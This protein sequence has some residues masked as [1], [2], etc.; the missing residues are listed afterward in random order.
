[1]HILFRQ[2]VVPLFLMG[3]DFQVGFLFAVCLQ[4]LWDL[5]SIQSLGN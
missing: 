1:M 4:S 2:H 3:C 5:A